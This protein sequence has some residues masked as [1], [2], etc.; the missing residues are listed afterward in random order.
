M[1]LESVLGGHVNAALL[2]RKG[3]NLRARLEFHLHGTKI[4]RQLHRVPRGK[5]N[6]PSVAHR[7]F[8]GLGGLVGATSSLQW[9]TGG[10]RNDKQNLAARRTEQQKSQ[11]GEIAEE[12]E[13]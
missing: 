2:L 5:T 4:D 6:W 7:S 3:N 1:W 11:T 12:V 9:E 8:I 13:E 10:S